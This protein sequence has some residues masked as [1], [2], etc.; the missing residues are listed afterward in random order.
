MMISSLSPFFPA[1]FTH[2]IAQVNLS[3]KAG[4]QLNGERSLNVALL[5]S[6]GFTVLAIAFLTTKAIVFIGGPTSSLH[7]RMLQIPSHSFMSILSF[8][9]PTMALFPL[10]FYMKM[11]PYQPDPG[12]TKGFSPFSTVNLVG[13]LVVQVELPF[14]PILAYPKM[15]FRLLVV[16]HPRHGNSTFV[17]TLPFVPNFNLLPSSS[18]DNSS[19]SSLSSFT[20]PPSPTHNIISYFTLSL[21]TSQFIL[22]AR[23]WGFCFVLLETDQRKQRSM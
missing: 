15:S 23:L 16:G 2:A 3:A 20:P 19:H 4:K 5:L 1:A 14:M 11:A 21:V 7:L 8:M 18:A 12:L 10:S 22:G 13:I 9:T 17:T 6:M